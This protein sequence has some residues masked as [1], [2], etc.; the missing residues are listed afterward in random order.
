MS[1]PRI[2]ATV[3]ATFLAAAACNTAP[4]P[5]EP[6]STQA[7]GAALEWRTHAPV[8]TPRTEVAAAALDGKIYVIGGFD[9]GGTV[10]TVEIYDPVT[11]SWSDGPQLPIAVNHAMA[12][13][14]GGDLY[15]FGGYRGPGLN[16]ATD[17]AFVFTNKAWRELPR[18][19]AT[20]AAGGASFARGKFWITGGVAPRGLATKTF[21]FD[22]DRRHW[23]TRA[24]V[25][26][27]REHLGVA[28]YKGRVYVVGGRTAGFATNLDAA[29]RFIVDRRRWRKLPDLPTARGGLAATAS[30]NGFIVAAGGEGPD[31]TFDEVEAYDVESQNWMSLPRMP[32]ARH[33]LGVVAIGSVIYVLAGGPQPGLTFTDANESLDLSSLR[34]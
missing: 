21:S 18:M 19:P 10:A 23:R 22:P 28:A 12:A 30:S 33:G 14:G 31:G 26:T 17:R 3:V 24:G 11:D 29:E 9:D 5:S 16:N 34:N 15:L 4:T 20:R 7:A 13:S 1:R 8:P 32:T 27:K 6:P 2:F 25:R